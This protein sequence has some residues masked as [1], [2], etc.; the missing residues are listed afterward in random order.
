[1]KSQMCTLC[2]SEVAGELFAKKNVPYYSC[3]VCGLVFMDPTHW[4]SR[5]V[6]L[7]RYSEHNNDG[8]DPG[9]VKHLMDIGERVA[10]ATKPGEQ[11]LD[12]G[13]GPTPVMAAELRER[14]LACESYDPIFFD[15]RALLRRKYDFVTCCEAVEHFHRPF[16]EFIKLYN[17]LEAG[18]SLGI[19][20]APIEDGIDYERWYYANDWT[21]VIFF[22]EKTFEWIADRFG[23]TILESDK[24]RVVL[25]KDRQPTAV[26]V[27]AGLICS[28][29]KYLVARR[30]EGA[31]AGKWEFPGGKLVDGETPSDALRREMLEELG[32]KV[33][34]GSVRGS[35]V[36]PASRQKWI[37]LLFVES[38]SDEEPSK[39]DAHSEW[40]WTESAKCREL[41][42]AP[43]D[44]AFVD[45]YGE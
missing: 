13:C 1:M 5:D 39:M 40:R 45:M 10:S 20:T 15:D 33:G 38:E 9:Y 6:E 34:D 31:M 3:A 24:G 2:G 36:F 19:K 29:G 21:H 25:R 44:L 41:D 4:P 26:Q 11:G 43:A 30:S 23:M 27:A 18:G 7:E 22:R 28:D 16:V 8:N 35:L 42:M 14:G 32:M 17:M 12:Y 37:E